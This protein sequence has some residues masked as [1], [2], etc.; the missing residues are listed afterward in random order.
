MTSETLSRYNCT[1]PKVTKMLKL[2][3]SSKNISGVNF[4]K[5]FQVKKQHFSAVRETGR[6][7]AISYISGDL[8]GLFDFFDFPHHHPRAGH[9]PCQE[10]AHQA[11]LEPTSWS[12]A[13]SK[14][15]HRELPTTAM[16]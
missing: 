12:L 16:A 2:M 1:T 7:G 9:S 13:L 5:Y 15:R 4:V 11:V 14:R 6:F 3:H 8:E 10:S